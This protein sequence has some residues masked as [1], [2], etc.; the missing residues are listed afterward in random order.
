MPHWPPRPSRRRV[1]S[2]GSLAIA[3][4]LLLAGILPARPEITERWGWSGSWVYPVGD[5]APREVSSP[6][7]RGGYRV[8]RG[9]RER[10]GRVAP[11]R[12]VDLA[13]GRGGGP[14]RAAGNGMV[15]HVSGSGWNRGF[16]RHVVLAHRLAEGALVYSVYAHLA[17]R[18]VAVQRGQ[19]VRA[20]SILG[21][22]GMSGRATSPHL[23][24][25]IRQP[26]DPGA[27]WERAPVVDPLAFI[28]ARLPAAR[29]DTA[30]SRP[31]LEWAEC[32][33][34]VPPGAAWDGT[35]SRAE[36]WRALLA[37][38]RHPLEAVPADAESLRATLI[39]MRLLP[40]YTR[41]DPGEPLGWSELARD[42]RTARDRGLRLPPSPVR[43]ETR[44]QDCLRE[45]GTGS[46]LSDSG[47]LVEG[48]Q[49][50]P[51]RADV[52][53]MLA[54]LAGDAPARPARGGRPVT[55]SGPAG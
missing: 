10:D 12:G 18:S 29:P 7:G 38:T 17:P 50:H 46:P 26:E 33:A 52:F 47:F 54:D 2:I 4:P 41:G 20:G 19:F 39:G 14:V 37:A 16:G 45:I 34:L 31:Y 42:L 53:L 6:D 28:A 23:H 5:H 15:V 8:V 3:A 13:N 48:C 43:A 25:E 24:F 35:P 22:V 21:R 32:A 30:W 9:P 11:H 49:G 40:E 36:W 27:R 1:P 51:R 55:P 44:R